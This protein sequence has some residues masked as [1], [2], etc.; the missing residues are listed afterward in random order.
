[1]NYVNSAVKIGDILTFGDYWNFTYWL[2]IGF[3][4]QINGQIDT[5]LV[6]FNSDMLGK[7]STQIYTEPLDNLCTQISKSHSKMIWCWRR[8]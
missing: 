8:L 7:H 1:M 2:V 5:K 6:C 3:T 4:E